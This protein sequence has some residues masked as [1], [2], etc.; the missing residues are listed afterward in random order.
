[1]KDI[2]KKLTKIVLLFLMVYSF[3][4]AVGYLDVLNSKNRTINIYLDDSKYDISY[5]KK[6]SNIEEKDSFFCF[7][8]RDNQIVMNNELQRKTNTNVIYVYGDLEGFIKTPVL[9]EDDIDGCLIDEDTSYELFGSEDVVGRKININ[10][11]TVIVRG[12]QKESKNTI[13]VR[14]LDTSKEK[15]DSISLIIPDKEILEDKNQG[16]VNEYVNSFIMK[17]DL[18]KLFVDS[19]M[20]GNIANLGMIFFIIIIIF[21]GLE[22]VFRKINKYKNKPVL[23]CITILE[24][25]IYIWIMKNIAFIFLKIPVEI[26]PN[27]WSNFERW[28]EIIDD[29]QKEISY[30]I[31]SKK[32]SVDIL[33]N[34]AMLKA[35]LYLALAIFIFMLC[36]KYIKIINIKELFLLICI[37]SICS[38]I[39]VII[40]D[41]SMLNCNYICIWSVL[42]VH[43]IFEYISC[44][45]KEQK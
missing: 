32:Y 13:I 45:C 28:S 25:I 33:R 19:N 14:E 11:R 30:F 29:Y 37:L 22:N 24:S 8:Q 27:K 42:P 16:N 36:K 4:H 44:Y 6:F 20:Y 3:G 40:A 1:M 39:T 23:K 26:I 31:C 15:F 35:T 2:L 41:K 43:F 10:E 34:E 21:Y 18:N 38:F 9:F 5:F 17:Y 7:R 12:I